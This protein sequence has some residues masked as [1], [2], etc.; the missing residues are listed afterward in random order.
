MGWGDSFTGFFAGVLFLLSLSPALL[1]ASEDSGSRLSDETRRSFERSLN[2]LELLV[3]EQERLLSETGGELE[4]MRTLL[5]DSQQKRQEL[6]RSLRSMSDEIDRL[7]AS[8]E[9]SKADLTRLNETL[10]ESENAL[11]SL[12][13]SWT[14]YRRS[15]RVQMWSERV[16]GAS[17]LVG[18]FFLG[19]SL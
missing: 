9:N 15:V 11:A 7:T 4:S 10:Q 6:D 16:L 12:E 18:A 17:L 2:E 8:N 3:A 5:S 19:L 1:S 13:R 14:S